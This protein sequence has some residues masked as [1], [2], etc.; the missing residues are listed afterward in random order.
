MW[1]I[2]MAE[3]MAA[4]P[5]LEAEAAGAEGCAIDAGSADAK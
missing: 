1:G 3:V 4:M 2:D 5:K